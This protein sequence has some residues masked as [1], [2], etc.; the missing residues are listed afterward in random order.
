MDPSSYESENDIHVI[1]LY[2]WGKISNKAVNNYDV[3]LYLGQIHETKF[4]STIPTG[5]K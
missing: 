1:Y 4:S 3:C 2:M 5:V